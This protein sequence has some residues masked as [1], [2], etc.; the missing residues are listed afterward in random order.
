M[1]YDDK[2]LFQNLLAV[3]KF[4]FDTTELNKLKI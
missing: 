2:L 3:E 4:R 1:A